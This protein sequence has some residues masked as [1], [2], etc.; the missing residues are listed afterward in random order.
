MEPGNGMRYQPRYQRRYEHSP[1]NYEQQ[2]DDVVK[3]PASELMT[4]REKKWLV[5]IQLMILI[6]DDVENKD[7][8]YVVSI[9]F[10]LMF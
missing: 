2:D 3:L 1:S 8:Y 4:S 10:C 5:K 7:Y 6:S 9:L